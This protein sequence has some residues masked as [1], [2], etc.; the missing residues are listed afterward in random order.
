MIKLIYANGKHQGE[1]YRIW[2]DYAGFAQDTLNLV[3]RTALDNKLSQKAVFLHYGYGIAADEQGRT[4]Y[5]NGILG[6]MNFWIDSFPDLIFVCDSVQE[7]EDEDAPQDPVREKFY[8]WLNKL[9]QVKGMQQFRTS[10]EMW[11]V[12]AGNESTE[13]IPIWEPN[14]AAPDQLLESYPTIAAL[15]A[16]GNLVN[17]E[18]QS[19]AMAGLWAVE[20]LLDGGSAEQV[21]TEMQTYA[22]SDDAAA[23]LKGRVQP[24]LGVVFYAFL[25]AKFYEEIAEFL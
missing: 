11:A 18:K 14:L 2:K 12:Y 23:A 7:D 21:L 25:T 6:G 13:E 22:A 5:T 1:L 3:A 17:S 20:Q 16:A 15:L 24:E 10:N 19:E 9:G 4:G 8:Y